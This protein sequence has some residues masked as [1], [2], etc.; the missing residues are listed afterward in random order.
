MKIGVDATSWFNGRGYGRFARELLPEL[1]SVGREHRFVLFIEEMNASRLD[2]DAEN[3]T[4]RV[5][6]CGE[7][8]SAAASADGYRS[9]L[10]LLRFGAAVA[11]ERPDVMFFPTVYAFFPV[12]FGLR[13][14]VTVHDTI[15]ERYPNLTLPSARAR[16]FWRM[17]VRLA[18]LQS[19]LVLT[20]SR[21]SARD[22]SERL[23]VPTR[24]LRVTSEAP[25]AVY[26]PASDEAVERARRACDLPDGARWFTY[27]GGFNPH[28]RL[29]V[30]VKAH[31]AL[32]RE[33]EDPPH[34]LLVGSLSSDVF[35]ACRTE[36]VDLIRKEG[37]ESLVHWTG[38]VADEDLRALHTGALA[39]VLP[40]ECEGF[41]LP[42]VEAA[43]CGA[44][45]V[46][47]R[48]SPL[49]ELLEGGGWFVAPG[50]VDDL[51]AALSAACGDEPGRRA[52]GRRARERTALL[53]WR[54]AARR[55]L[56][57]LEEA[58]A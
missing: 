50:R 23:G 39:C 46:A 48:E 28:K 21:Y 11:R 36:L 49:P 34:L 16:L 2:L 53:S 35:H 14:V 10:D 54:E 40:S 32:A 4:R 22:I 6:R 45:V 43:A 55:T 31:G 20:V 42:A 57:T 26:R 12:P 58:A 13:S 51:A 56:S 27:V 25:S 1:F 37:T 17:K 18:L 47:T 29:D 9:P 41:G 30:L 44:P 24:R 19:R 33:S 7:A 38:F 3:V 8:P 5:V 52:R 15:A